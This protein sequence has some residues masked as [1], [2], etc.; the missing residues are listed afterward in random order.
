MS[1]PT[2]LTLP[3]AATP[4]PPPSFPLAGL[5]LPILGAV[6]LFL[7]LRTPWVL[8]IAILGPLSVLGSMADQRRIRRRNA[9]R[10]QRDYSSEHRAVDERI[11]RHHSELRATWG[12]LDP[13]LDRLRAA[14]PGHWWRRVPGG[15]LRVGEGARASGIV[16]DGDDIGSDDALHRRAGEVSGAAVL[17]AGTGQIAVVGPAPLA[18]AV[19]RAWVL[20]SMLDTAPGRLRV[21]CDIPEILGAEAYPHTAPAG[22]T[23]TVRAAGALSAARSEADAPGDIDVLVARFAEDLRGHTGPVIDLTA[24]GVHLWPEGTRGP[25]TRVVPDVLGARG[26]QSARIP[27]IERARARHSTHLDAAPHPLEV[28]TPLDAGS[29]ATLDAPLGLDDEGQVVCVDL[30]RDGPHAL[31]GGTTGSG[32]SELLQ[33][34]LAA[35]AARNTPQQLSIVLI[36][37]KGGTG[38]ARIARLPHTAGLLTDLDPTA[39]ERALHGLRAEVLRRERALRAGDAADIDELGPS[40]RPARLL[41]VIDEYRAAVEQQPDLRA[42]IVDLA[43]RGRALG[44][45]LLLCTQQPATGDALAANCALRIGLRMHS[46]GDSRAL[47]GDPGAAAFTAAGRAMVAGSGPLRVVQVGRL[48]ADE[49]RPL[50]A[51]GPAGPAARIWAPPLPFPLLADARGASPSTLGLCDRPGAREH[52]VFDPDVWSR[53]LLITGPAAS[54]RSRAL[55]A[56]AVRAGARGLAVH[57]LGAGRGGAGPDALESVWDGVFEQLDR[58]RR[59]G[60]EPSV[61][62]IDDL[63][64]V[65]ARAGDEL[66]LRLRD[67]LRALSREGAAHGVVLLLAAERLRAGHDTLAEGLPELRLGALSLGSDH[68]RRAGNVPPGRGLWQ[69]D[70]VQ[71]IEGPPLSDWA[72]APTRVPLPVRSGWTLLL[73]ADPAFVPGVRIRLLGIASDDGARTALLHGPERLGDAAAAPDSSAGEWIVLTPADGIRYADGLLAARMRHGILIDARLER[74]YRYLGGAAEP[75]APSTGPAWWSLDGAGANPLRHTPPVR[76]QPVPGPAHGSP[77]AAEEAP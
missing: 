24:E 63:D 40:G 72:P 73:T 42:V 69:G 37:F 52:E 22:A 28:R 58:V 51:P 3:R 76:D 20:R 77:G 21:R 2:R 34:W 65:L 19:V 50:E 30:R 75:P 15:P 66:A 57:I 11:R 5:V 31:I 23:F 71:L 27:I 56:L 68:G 64:L 6:V 18:H 41:I 60:P 53:G 33:S 46:A 32:K 47:L 26:W 39:V 1:A 25:G 70:A 36:D 35:L 38:L 13:P 59:G 17:V 8:L 45:H 29:P 74:E 7:I 44:I 55:G 10:A 12:E 16:L 62:V 67:G 14:D 49:I 54:G 61:L 4:P 9:R 43:A 48:R